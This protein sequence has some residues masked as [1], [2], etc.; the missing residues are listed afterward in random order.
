MNETIC[1]GFRFTSPQG[2]NYGAGSFDETY[3]SATG[4]DSTV[5]FV[6]TEQIAYASTVNETICNGSLFTSPQ[7]NSYGAGS[8][9]ETYTSA[10]GCDSTVTFVMTEQIA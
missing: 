3:T 7:G 8:F 5:T 4:C 6:V 1:N 2:N 9:D 10:T